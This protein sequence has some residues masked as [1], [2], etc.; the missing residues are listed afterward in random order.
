MWL[1]AEVQWCI[2]EEIDQWKLELAYL[3]DHDLRYTLTKNKEA[4]FALLISVF[5]CSCQIFFDL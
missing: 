1:V 4:A 5:F 2:K 3:S